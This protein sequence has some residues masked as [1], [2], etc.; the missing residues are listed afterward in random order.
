MAAQLTFTNGPARRAEKWWIA[1]A[2]SSLPVPVSPV[3]R[4]VTSTRAA[5]RM[6]CRAS[7]IFGLHQI[8]IS[9]RMRPPSCSGAGP[10]ASAWGR[11]SLSI[12]CWSSSRLSGLCRMASTSIGTVAT[13][14]S[15]RLET[16]MIGPAFRPRSFRHSVSSAAS[17]PLPLKSTSVK[18]KLPSASAS[19]ASSGD[20]AATHWY[21]RARRKPRSP[22]CVAASTSTTSALCSVIGNDSSLGSVTGMSTDRT[23]GQMPYQRRLWARE[24]L[25]L[26]ILHRKIGWPRATAIHRGWREMGSSGPSVK[27]ITTSGIFTICAGSWLGQGSSFR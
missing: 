21:P 1:R 14:L 16:A 26:L 9:R 19:W 7:S 22:N 24:G 17:V 13:P 12:A 3:T 27:P 15:C 18:V 6:I 4:T 23:E 11:T 25:I 8:S 20:E 5:S 10:S 2:T